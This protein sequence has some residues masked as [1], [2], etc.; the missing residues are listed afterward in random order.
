[1]LSVVKSDPVLSLPKGLFKKQIIMSKDQNDYLENMK[2]TFDC[3][4]E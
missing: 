1:M 2:S 4:I 3:K